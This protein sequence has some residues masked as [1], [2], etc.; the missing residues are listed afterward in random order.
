VKKF[1]RPPESVVKSCHARIGRPIANVSETVRQRAKVSQ[2][3]RHKKSVSLIFQIFRQ[4]I[5]AK[6]CVVEELSASRNSVV[7]Q[8]VVSEIQGSHSSRKLAIT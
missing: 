8:F 4:P 2:G 7:Y 6:S 1:G 3:K 5:E